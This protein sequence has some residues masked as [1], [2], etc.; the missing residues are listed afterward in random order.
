MDA[1][2]IYHILVYIIYLYALV[3]ENVNIGIGWST[4]GGKFKY[5]TFLD[6]CIQTIYFGLSIVNDLFGSN[7]RPSERIKRTTLQR[8]R[9]NFLAAIVFP[10][11]TFVVVTFW[12][13][14]AVDRELVYPKAL[15]KVIPQWLNHIMHT[16]VLPFLLIEKFMIYHQYPSRK[17][18]ISTLLTFGAVYLIW[19]LWI[20]YKADL[21]VYPILKVMQAHERVIF[22]AVLMALFISI[23]IVG[24]SLTRFLWRKERHLARQKQQS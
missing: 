3:Y 21:W 2:T 4:Y 1:H 12:G 9:D 23:Y 13:I 17:S 22:I 11:G 6:T 15:D 14:Y 19:I 5:L 20:A 24:E 8:W 16:T 7:V 10:V 18:G